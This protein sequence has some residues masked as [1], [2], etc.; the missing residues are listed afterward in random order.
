MRI[1][2]N[3]CSSTVRTR[4]AQNRFGA[5]PLGEAAKAANSKIVALLL[6]AGAPVD[7]ANK[8]GETALMLASR[9]GSKDVVSQLIASGRERERARGVARP[10]RAHVGGRRRAMPIS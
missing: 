9:T 3:G 1:S 5:T 6:K 10:D 7:A 8:D 2:S 4:P